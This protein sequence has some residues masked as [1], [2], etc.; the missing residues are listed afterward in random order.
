MEIQYLNN[1]NLKIPSII[2]S[3]GSSVDKTFPMIYKNSKNY[4]MVIKELTRYKFF[5]NYFNLY[6]EIMLKSK[7]KENIIKL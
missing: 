4:L 6:E 5:Y 2:C 1:N 3:C 7:L